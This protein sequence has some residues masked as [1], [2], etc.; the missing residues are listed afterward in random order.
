MLIVKLFFLNWWNYERFSL[1]WLRLFINERCL[2]MNIKS[3]LSEWLE[4][5]GK[6]SHDSAEFQNWQLEL[7]NSGL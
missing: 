3:F 7:L 1:C 6:E 4:R 2:T 5:R